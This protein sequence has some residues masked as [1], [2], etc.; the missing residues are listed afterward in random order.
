MEVVLAQFARFIAAALGMLLNT[1]FWLIIIGAV[2]SWVNPDP[3]NPIVRFIHG[4][5]EPALYQVR[6]RLPFVVVGGLDLSPVVIILCIMF[7]Q[8]VIVDSLR[9][10]ADG[11]ALRAG[12]Y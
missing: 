10:L 5:T 3:R 11:I 9:R 4:V 6:R 8:M 2:L 12:A 1:F 7:A